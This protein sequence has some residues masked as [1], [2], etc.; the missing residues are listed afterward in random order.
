MGTKFN[1]QFISSFT[2]SPRTED[3]TA[4]TNFTLSIQ[5]DNE[6][7]IN[8]SKKSLRNST[9]KKNYPASTS[10]E[11]CSS[12]SRKKVKIEDECNNSSIATLNLSPIQTMDV[13]DYAATYAKFL[14][15][16]EAA[17]R[18]PKQ[19]EDSCFCCK[20]GGELIECDWRG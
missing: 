1:V 8:S 11:L 17:K 5:N 15:E 16:R 20:D 2:V 4:N 6:K 14:I 3:G 12:S 9:L 19:S 10:Q 13:V 7:E 18:F